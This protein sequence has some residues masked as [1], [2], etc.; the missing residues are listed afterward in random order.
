MRKG[1]DQ[2]GAALAEERL[3]RRRGGVATVIAAELRAPAAK[4]ERAGLASADSGR[5]DEGGAGMVLSFL[6]VVFTLTVRE[7]RYFSA[8]NLAEFCHPCFSPG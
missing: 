5:A 1:D 6:L 8:S 3:R 4:E 2:T 7:F